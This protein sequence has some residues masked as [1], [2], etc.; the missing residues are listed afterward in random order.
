MLV[1][2]D[3]RNNKKNFYAVK[4]KKRRKGC[5]PQGATAV[6]LLG[7]DGEGATFVGCAGAPLGALVVFV[8][9]CL[10][11]L[12]TAA[13]SGVPAAMPPAA[14]IT[15]AGEGLK[16]TLMAVDILVTMSS[17]VRTRPNT[18]QRPSKGSTRGRREGGNL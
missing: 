9:A 7:L 1:Q 12:S 16:L 10:S 14:L 11:S 8:E 2:N 18:T 13:H 6:G 15:I 17:P 5:R 4:E 3:G